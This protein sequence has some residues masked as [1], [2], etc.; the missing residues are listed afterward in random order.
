MSGDEVTNIRNGAESKKRASAADIGTAYHRIMEFLDFGKITGSATDMDYI[1]ERAA[2]LKE[3]GAIDEDVYA[4]LDL[5]HIAAFFESDLGKRALAASR[6]GS[7]KREKPFTLKTARNGKEMLVQGVIDC[8]FE[9]DG[10]MILIDYKSSY[11]RPG[12]DREAELERI[13]DEYKVQ[14]E[15]YS[16][17]VEKGTGMEVSE[18]YLY[19]FT[20]SEAVRM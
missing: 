2:F 3:K 9:E 6:R 20:I 16:E 8:C 4:S 12:A 10:R 7:L 14:I 1:A 13:R 11:I 19:L 18:A 17:A 5:S 15:L